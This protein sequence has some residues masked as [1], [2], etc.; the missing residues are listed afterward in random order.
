MNKP[1]INE[2]YE[3]IKQYLL[4][5]LPWLNSPADETEVEHTGD[6]DADFAIFTATYRKR[7]VDF[8]YTPDKTIMW[9]RAPCDWVQVD[10]DDERNTE[11]QMFDALYGNLESERETLRIQLQKRRDDLDTYDFCDDYPF[12]SSDLDETC[13]KMDKEISRLNGIIRLRKKI[14]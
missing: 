5:A 6:N 1:D 7:S 11:R 9:L 14:N 12:S 8:A 10:G 13:Q 4:E 3:T 2:S